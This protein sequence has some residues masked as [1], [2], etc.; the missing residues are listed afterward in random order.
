M[1]QFL[2]KIGIDY[3]IV[4]IISM[5]LLAN[6]WPEGGLD[7]SPYSLGTLAN[8]GVTV[9][10]FFYGLRL[11]REKLVT[12]LTN[13]KLHVVVQMSTFLLFPLLILLVKPLFGSAPD[14]WPGSFFL[15]S[16]PSTVS[17]SVVMVSI[18][19]GNIPA[20]IFNASISGI[21]GIFLTPIWMSIA[22]GPGGTE[23]GDLKNIILKL[24]LQVLLPVILGFVLSKK[25]GAFAERNKKFLKLYDQSIILIIVYTSF[26]ESF[27]KNLFDSLSVKELFVLAAAMAVLFFSVFYLVSLFSSWLNFNREDRITAVFCGSKKSLVHGTVMSKVLFLN[28]SAI[29][30]ILLPLM[31]YHATQLII[32]AMIAQNWSEKK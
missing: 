32:A 9:I 19:S 29:G 15:A 11:S 4:G 1:V 21:L 25:W 6:L 17:S 10:F 28:S 31:I 14:L 24:T 27:A 20:A 5:I 18:A 12:G 22:V 3:F 26:S 8:W 16:L 7:T 30:L 13:W 2:K 23:G